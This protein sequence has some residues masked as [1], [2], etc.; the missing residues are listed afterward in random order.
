MPSS[1]ESSGRAAGQWFCR[2][3]FYRPRLGWR[4]PVNPRCR[5]VGQPPE[6]YGQN[7]FLSKAFGCSVVG[8]L[9]KEFIDDPD[10]NPINQVLA[11]EI[12]EKGRVRRA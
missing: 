6:I 8:G 3:R 9:A 4:Y 2:A 12:A 11:K 5:F 1:L 7:A 10:W